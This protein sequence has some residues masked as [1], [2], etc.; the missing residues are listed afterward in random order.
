M[1]PE[2]LWCVN[3]LIQFALVCMEKWTFSVEPSASLDKVLNVGKLHL[4]REIAPTWFIMPLCRTKLCP[5]A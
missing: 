4:L 1:T 3:I 5:D 2:I